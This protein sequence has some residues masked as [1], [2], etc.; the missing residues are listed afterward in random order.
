MEELR[1]ILE[2]VGPSNDTL[3]WD[4]TLY[5]LFLL[6]VVILLLLPDG[7]TLGT[8][9]SVGV[10]LCLFMDKTYAFGHLLDSGPYSPEYCH[11]KIFVGTYLI[12]AVIFAAPLT[13]AAST[14]KGSV[15]TLGIIAGIGGAAYMFLRWYSDQREV[16]A[17]NITCFDSEA[18][19][20][21]ASMVLVLGR[22]ALRNRLGSLTIYR[23]VP[24]AVLGDLAAHEVEV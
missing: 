22:V 24:G 23:D 6:N 19:V 12:R 11:A 5:V 7:S 9:L 18:M 4:I 10:I 1:A 21:S 3:G 8:V 14:D 13:V 17:P 20:R 16:S 2:S 15:R